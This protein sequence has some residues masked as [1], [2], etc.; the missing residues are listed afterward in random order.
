MLWGFYSNNQSDKACCKNV[1]WW[2]CHCSRLQRPSHNPWSAAPSRTCYFSV[3]F[4]G[5]YKLLLSSDEEV[6]G[7][8]RN[9]SKETDG[10]HVSFGVSVI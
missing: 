4:A 6:F 3:T 2:R 10:D 8:W 9:L 1:S 7:G 5:T